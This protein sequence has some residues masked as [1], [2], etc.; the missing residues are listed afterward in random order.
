MFVW[1][2]I[3]MPVPKSY[4]YE[5]SGLVPKIYVEQMRQHYV[6]EF[7]PCAT[8]VHMFRTVDDYGNEGVRISLKYDKSSTGYADLYLHPACVKYACGKTDQTSKYDI[9][10]TKNVYHLAYPMPDKNG[11]MAMQFD[12]RDVPCGEILDLLEDTEKDF[13]IRFEKL[14]KR[15][16]PSKRADLLPTALLP[17]EDKYNII[18]PDYIYDCTQANP[19][20][21]TDAPW[22]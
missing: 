16:W 21:Y 19:S 10:L 8:A 3:I 13:K 6:K 4:R 20:P 2:S 1:R 14:R 5:H 9:L 17:K 15:T 22:F 11:K 18:T 12:P 7:F